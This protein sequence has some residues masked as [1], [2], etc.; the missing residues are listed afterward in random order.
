MQSQCCSCCDEGE[1]IFTYLLNHL[2]IK[3]YEDYRRHSPEIIIQIC[4]CP[5]ALRLKLQFV[6]HILFQKISNDKNLGHNSA[7]PYEFVV[8]T[9]DDFDEG[10]KSANENSQ[11]IFKNGNNENFDATA[12][13]KQMKNL[14]ENLMN[15]MK[16]MKSSLTAEINAKSLSLESLGFPLTK[17]YHVQTVADFLKD[18]EEYRR[19]FVNALTNFI[20]I[21]PLN[22]SVH[23]ICNIIYHKLFTINFHDQKNSS[24]FTKFYKNIF[25]GNEIIFNTITEILTKIHNCNEEDIFLKALQRIWNL[26]CNQ[27]KSDE[28][29]NSSKRIKISHNLDEKEIAALIKKV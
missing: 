14:E 7:M 16:Q 25:D 26:Q 27:S 23:E 28:Q 9:E 18:N 15:E 2:K 21:L 19:S 1:R 11:E 5:E 6:D 22:L 12:I 24:E 3:H 10:R 13:I 17:N 8:K 20:K 29:S 4:N